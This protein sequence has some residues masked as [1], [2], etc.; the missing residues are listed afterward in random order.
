MKK[1]FIFM[2]LV[3]FGGGAYMY[4]NTELEP[5]LDSGG[6]G[7]N[8]L[9]DIDEVT[10]PDPEE[11]VVYEDNDYRLLSNTEIISQY[12]SFVDNYV[13]GCED[14]RSKY[15][16]GYSGDTF[17]AEGNASWW[18]PITSNTPSNHCS[19]FT[20]DSYT[21][22][23]YGTLEQ[24][25][26]LVTGV[27]F[28]HSP[29]FGGDGSAQL[30]T[31]L[32][33]NILST[34]LGVDDY[35]TL[36]N[37]T[38]YAD[39]TTRTNLYKFFNNEYG[40]GSWN[41]IT[42]T[43]DISADYDLMMVLGATSATIQDAVT[44]Q[45]PIYSAYNTHWQSNISYSLFDINLGWAGG[46]TMADI[47][48]TNLADSQVDAGLSDIIA[49]FELLNGDSLG[50]NTTSG[51]C[52]NAGC[53]FSAVTLTN[54]SSINIQ[55]AFYTPV[56]NIASV[57]ATYDNQGINIFDLDGQEWLKAAIALSDNLREQSTY[58]FLS[59]TGLSDHLSFY[60]VLY[61][62]MVIHYARPDNPLSLSLGEYSPNESA[63]QG[64][65]TVKRTMSFNLDALDDLTATGIYIKAG[66]TATI[67]RTDSNTE[68]V[69]LYINYHRNTSNSIYGAG[70]Y[71]YNR[72]YSDRSNAILLK[73]GES[74]QISTPKGGQLFV[75]VPNDNYGNQIVIEA[76]NVL[77]SPYLDSND[78]ESVNQFI[79][80][81][82]TTPFQWVD[83]HIDNFQLHSRTDM[84]RDV[85]SYYQNDIETYV[86]NTSYYFLNVSYAY[87]G[88][89]SE[90]FERSENIIE[91]FNS[92][93]LNAQANDDF[94][95]RRI[96]HYYADEPT[97][98]GACASGLVYDGMGPLDYSPIDSLYYFQPTRWIEIHELGH[99]L[100]MNM[101]SVNDQNAYEVSN[102]IF[103]V[104]S[105]RQ[106]AA[107]NGNQYYDTRFSYTSAFDLIKAGTLWNTSAYDTRKIAFYKQIEYASGDFDFHPKLA[108]MTRILYGYRLSEDDFNSVKNGLGLSNYSYSD[109]YDSSVNRNSG[110]ILSEN[111]WTCIASSLIAGRDLSEFFEGFGV[112]VSD[113]AKAQIA[114]MGYTKQA[115]GR[116]MYY[117]PTDPSN[118]NNVLTA[119]DRYTNKDDYLI[120]IATG[121]WTSPV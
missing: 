79:I 121:S 36:S 27:N 16:D 111:D 57:I 59:Y 117:V 101:T 63:I 78:I 14:I 29:T 103:V 74:I 23:Y 39:S 72:P 87:A 104:E 62:D 34:L 25:E 46:S 82:E 113:T 55:D 31:E 43:T 8:T 20:S 71:S 119:F 106:Y 98:G 118:A 21:Y 70:I 80:D 115:L 13:T 92:R 12:S 6:G 17:T 90:S 91:F 60:Q 66:E 89:L 120:D 64:L 112:S 22:S 88:I 48:I 32:Q 33:N 58:N 51:G 4:I 53:T 95:Y 41:H 61:T 108:I 11:E 114:S 67:T 100:Q 38:I 69:Y 94:H 75:Q 84:M 28:F 73:A 35:K 7:S 65:E 47:N 49:L 30:F 54:D 97:C 52:G 24:S 56:S 26:Y 2:L 45:K 96:Q 81:L 5:N 109:V 107:D 85:L 10:P 110:F 42:V 9:P 105:R 116:V 18:T 83:L 3:A 1:L 50:L 86:Y 93:E 102:E 99:G 76:N 15:L 68:D 44:R 40:V 77:L 19:I 37:I